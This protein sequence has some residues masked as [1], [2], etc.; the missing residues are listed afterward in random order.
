MTPNAEFP[1]VFVSPKIWTS[2]TTS[3]QSNTCTRILFAEPELRKATQQKASLLCVTRDASRDN[4][5]AALMSLFVWCRPSPYV[6]SHY[7]DG[8]VC[9]CVWSSVL[10]TRDD[11][12]ETREEKGRE[13]LVEPHHPV[14]DSPCT[15]CW[16]VACTCTDTSCGSCNLH[17]LVLLGKALGFYSMLA[18]DIQLV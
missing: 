12:T 9:C 4:K 11:C 5:M 1:V 13:R 2:A 10:T 6:D 17:T 18:P 14:T 8:I 3:L 15:H 7:S 16:L